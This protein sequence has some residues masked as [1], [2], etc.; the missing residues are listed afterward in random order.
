VA[1]PNGCHPRRD[2]PDRLGNACPTSRLHRGPIR[3][4]HGRT[5][6][7]HAATEIDFSWNVI[8]HGAGMLD[9]GGAI[10]G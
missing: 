6:I 8:D 3:I 10:D 4:D 1:H 5:E 7:D 2:F 9:L